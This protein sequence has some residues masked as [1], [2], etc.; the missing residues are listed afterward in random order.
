MA[1][2]LSVT[3]IGFEDQVSPRTPLWSFYLFRHD[4]KANDDGGQGFLEGLCG[5]LRNTLAHFPKFC[6][7]VAPLE[8]GEVVMVWAG[9]EAN[10]VFQSVSERTVD[11]VLAIVEQ[12]AA[13]R[14]LELPEARDCF[15][16][17]AIELKDGWRV[18]FRAHHTVADG[19]VLKLL[20]QGVAE[21][22]VPPVPFD[23]DDKSSRNRIADA[24]EMQ[25]TL[26]NAYFFLE[27]GGGPSQPAQPSRDYQTPT[28][29]QTYHVSRIKLKEHLRSCRPGWM[30]D[31]SLPK[32][33]GS[34]NESG[35]RSEFGSP[36]FRSLTTELGAHV[37]AARIEAEVPK[38]AKRAIHSGDEATIW[39]P[40]DVRNNYKLGI[41]DL[42]NAVVP[43]PAKV[44]VSD[45][46]T[47][48]RGKPV[49][50]SNAAS[51]IFSAITNEI[52]CVRSWPYLGERKRFINSLAGQD[53]RNLGIRY[54]ASDPFWIHVS[55]GREAGADSEFTWYEKA[56]ADEK[57]TKDA[58]KKKADAVRE[59]DTYVLSITLPQKAMD[60]LKS[61]P[62]FKT[63]MQDIGANDNPQQPVTVTQG[64]LV[65]A[66][67][68]A[69]PDQKPY[70]WNIDI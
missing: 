68:H 48:I 70:P 46:F 28:E 58:H 64:T 55:D 57:D 19:G 41:I 23:Y 52:T 18:A 14:N 50:A 60:I 32:E 43:A 44:R 1:H 8:N 42:G 62:K 17:D 2:P 61:Q 47:M 30:W 67:A 53:Y 38:I 9:H 6:T 39:I 20:A 22:N 7:Q 11:E 51:A 34:K 59:D 65:K 21:G 69:P 13:A 37:L 3:R 12:P 27:D 29:T 40:V 26:R 33:S 36:E 5:N 63:F 4:H 35:A 54:D 31:Y 24:P 66:E 49:E 15:R 25:R 56:G 45:I 16:V 10:D